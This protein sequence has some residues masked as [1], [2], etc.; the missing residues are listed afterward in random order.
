MTGAPDRSRCAGFTLVEALVST[1]LMSIIL[2]ALAAITA[3]WLPSWDRGFARLQRGGVLAASLE[4]LTNDIAAAQYVSAG[5]DNDPPLFDGGELSV[6]FVRTTL[7]PNTVTGLEVVRLAEAGSEHGPA[8]VR[9]TAP[10]PI[11][12]S[13]SLANGDL[14]FANPVVMIRAPYRVSFSYAGPDRVWQS[15]WHGQVALPR[16]VR[17]SLRD[18]ATSMVL[19]V[20]TSTLVHAE[21]PARCTWVKTVAGCPM[22]NPSGASPARSS[23]DAGGS[24]G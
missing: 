9:S 7:A 20:S 14:L 24:G 11:G 17:V 15:A 3:Q 8:L 18:N 5:A 2:A 4:R 6:I 1:V 22:L 16:A 19:G 21:L 23:S 13:F 10:V 12:G